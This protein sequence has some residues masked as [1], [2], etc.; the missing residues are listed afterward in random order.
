MG[1]TQNI[2]YCKVEK[3]PIYDGKI[4]RN[5]Y[6][7]NEYRVKRDGKCVSPFSFPPEAHVDPSYIKKHSY[8]KNGKNGGF[9][10]ERWDK[11]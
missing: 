9:S 5:T 3:I 2:E 7:V 10:W 8:V 11:K 4:G 6:V 1:N